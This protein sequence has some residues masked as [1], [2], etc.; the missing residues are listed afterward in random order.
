MH[1]ALHRVSYSPYVLAAM[2]SHTA[3]M[4]EQCLEQQLKTHSTLFMKYLVF[5]DW[6]VAQIE[7]VHMRSYDKPRRFA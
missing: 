2:G 7:P 4:Q 5:R 1:P 6:H 3:H